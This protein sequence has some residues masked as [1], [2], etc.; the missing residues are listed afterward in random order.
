MRIGIPRETAVGETRVAGTPETVKKLRALGLDVV[1]ER[2]AGLASHFTDAAYRDAGAELV[3]ASETLAADIVFKVHK[4][5]FEQIR[6]MRR[7][8]TLICLLDMCYDDG[9]FDTLAAQ[10]VDSFALEMMPRIS[11]AQTMDVLSSQANIA[12]YRAVLEAARLYGRFFPLMMTSAGSAKPARVV[13]L[14]AGV[15]GLQ[16]IATA[17]RLGAQV[18]AY[19]VRPEVKE[20]VQS[21]GARFIEL[22]VGESGAGHGG[23]A[24]PLSEEAQRKEQALLTEELKKADIIVSTALIPCRPAPVLITEDAI[25]GMHEGA[26]VVD[27]A[28][29]SGGNCPLTE[30]DRIVTRHGVILCGITNFP[31]L[32]PSDASNFFARNVY[33]FLEFMLEPGAEGVR[34]KD[35]LADDVTS[36]TLITFQG[37]VRFETTKMAKKRPAGAS[38]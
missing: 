25:R 24:K 28:A 12:G 29:A 33:N 23:Y 38:A 30:P 8:A 26:V 5:T 9:T 14:G 1:V 35:F 36:M 18:W 11:R 19:D 10:G 17:R 16:A 3:S 27:M 22:D 20:Q 7:G 32:M 21:L 6:G 37:T 31:A 2:E 34:F 4:P 15:A 13:V